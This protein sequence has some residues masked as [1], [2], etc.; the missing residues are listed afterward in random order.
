MVT[1]SEE[2]AAHRWVRHHVAAATLGTAA[3]YGRAPGPN[4]SGGIVAGLVLAGVVWIAPPVVD[5][6]RSTSPPDRPSGPVAPTEKGPAA[7]TAPMEREAD[8]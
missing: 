5:L 2:L 8:R 6:V 3:P 7:P 4:A 1:R